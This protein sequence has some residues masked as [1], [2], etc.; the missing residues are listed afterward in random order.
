MHRENCAKLR[1]RGNERIVKATSEFDE[2]TAFGARGHAVM[3]LRGMDAYWRG[4]VRLRALVDDIENGFRH[5]SLGVP[6]VS[7]AERLRDFAALPVLLTPGSTPL[8]TKVAAQLAAEGAIFATAA[9]PDQAHVDPTVFYGAGCV[10]APTTRIGHM[11]RI[12][13]GVQALSDVIAHDCE[14]GDFATLG[15]HSS[16]YGHVR[17]G[18]GVAL[19]ASAVVT[20]GTRHRP[21]CIGDGAVIGVGAVVLRDVAAGER[22][23]GN[24]AMP[25]RQWVKLRRLLDGR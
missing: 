14:I 10:C 4:R 21:L 16:I 23:V 8:R 17:I 3:L 6:V 13:A 20:N 22:V 2:I 24:P 18:R 19:G 5:P 9:C 12:G 1:R 15:L 25:V 7:S 11:V